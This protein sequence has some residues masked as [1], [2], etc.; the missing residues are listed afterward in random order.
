MKTAGGG[1]CPMATRSPPSDWACGRC[2]T[3]RS[4]SSG[5]LGA[6]GRLPAHRHRAGLRQRGAA[7]AGRCATA[8]C[9]ARRSSSPR[10]SIP[11]RNDPAA[12]AE[13]SLERLG[14]DQIDLYIIHWPQGGRPGRGPGWRPPAS[15]GYARS[16]GVSNFSVAELEEL[17]GVADT[18]PVVNQVQFSPFEYRRELLE[19]C[20]RHDIALE[21][22]S[23]LGTGRHLGDARRG[24]DRRARGPHPGAGP[25]P[26]V[27]PARHDRAAQVDAPRAHRGERARSSTSPCPTRTWRRSTSSTRATAPTAARERKWW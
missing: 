13:K 23:P 22:Y 26:L 2:R 6:R 27:R 18:P 14:V 20:E 4:A 15:A 21:A 8:G 1:P 10:S 19:A 7:S 5:A 16:I 12:E 11:A 25:D 9:R 17:L 3:A 24:R